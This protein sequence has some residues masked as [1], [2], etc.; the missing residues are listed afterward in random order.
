MRKP[1]RNPYFRFK[2][3]AIRHDLCAMKVGTDG[4]LLG[5][6]ARADE[7][8]AQKPFRAL[9]IG[10]G[11]G[12]IA[13]MLAQRYSNATIYGIDIDEASALQARDNVRE[14]GMEGR[15]SIGLADF[16]AMTADDGSYDLI[17]SNP[18]FYAEDT[19]S[20]NTA[21]DNARHCSSLPFRDLISGASRL[22]SQEGL[23]AVVI[24]HSAA[25]GFIALCAEHKLYLLRRTNVRSTEKKAFNRVLL[26]FGKTRAK[27]TETDTL[28]LYDEGNKRSAAYERLTHD[29]YL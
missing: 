24:P 11:S 20:G 18:P 28:T 13:M 16:T 19:V 12:L 21:R 4:V 2:Q 10:T 23:L 3:F 1:Y 29:F 26:A 8:C 27:E 7:A 22:L 6:W 15:I 9:D 17:V 14:A 5:A 25:Q